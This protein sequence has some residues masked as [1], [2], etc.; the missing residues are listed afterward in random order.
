MEL[1]VVALA[2]LT[3]AAWGMGS[4]L[5]KLGLERGG[6]P[7]QAAFTV[8]LV[9]T[10]TYWVALV[11]QGENLFGH[12]LWVLGLFVGTGLAATALAR[13][14][15]FAGV[16]R[17]GAS[18]NSAGIN[19]RPVWASFMAVLFLGETI[20]L[21]MSL[22]IIVVVIGLMALAFSDGG[23][24]SGWKR[25]QLAF[26]LVAAL[27]FGAGN[28]ARKYAFEATRITA[29]EGVAINETA[30]LIGLVCFLVLRGNTTGTNLFQG[31][32]RAYM[33]FIGSGLLNALAL[34]TLFE[35]LN[36]GRVVLVDPLSSPTSLFAILFSFV[37]LRRI[38][39]VT[40]RLIVGAVLVVS[41]VVLITGPEV[42]AL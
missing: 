18:I 11:V 29:L 32:R 25:S 8:V 28:V 4:P 17:L 14:L 5:S 23:D 2:L 31:P 15:S 41:G 40:A 35:A 20:T 19:T 7:Y 9:S 30:G 33:F 13:V 36:R 39:R 3:A 27:L 42:L 37:F 24:I 22:G 16:E 34:F 6:T 12:P 26:P 38:E 21:Q 10:V 1:D